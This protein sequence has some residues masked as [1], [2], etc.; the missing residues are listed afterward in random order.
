MSEKV[1]SIF[2]FPFN[3]SRQEI[4]IFPSQ[5]HILTS[6]STIFSKYNYTRQRN[7]SQVI[8]CPT[9]ER[10]EG[11]KFFV[12]FHFHRPFLS[13]PCPVRG[14]FSSF[15]V[16][17]FNV[18]CVGLGRIFPHFF[19]PF[20]FHSSVF[21]DRISTHTASAALQSSQMWKKERIHF[22]LFFFYPQQPI[23]KT[24]NS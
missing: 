3:F 16:A 2:S 11:E 17:T 15:S 9:M 19:A 14:N 6:L 21:R 12:L 8:P 4:L 5:Y 1:Q 7:S 23:W 20:P 24:E 13:Y 18:V 10:I 22:W